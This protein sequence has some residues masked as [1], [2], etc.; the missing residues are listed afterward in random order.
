MLKWRKVPGHLKWAAW[1]DGRHVATVMQDPRGHTRMFVDAGRG[2]QE[3]YIT[4]DDPIGVPAWKLCAEN[5]LDRL[6]ASAKESGWI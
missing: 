1:R 3:C 2:M 4:N 5:A 6:E